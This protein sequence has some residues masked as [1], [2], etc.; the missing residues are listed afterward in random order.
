MLKCL[1]IVF[2]FRFFVNH[3]IFL[4]KIP[5]AERYAFK[6]NFISGPMPF[7]LYIFHGPSATC[8]RK[9]EQTSGEDVPSR[10]LLGSPKTCSTWTLV[11]RTN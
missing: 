7:Y 8:S 5:F 11:G 9:H 2:A 6:L 4:D 10:E 1:L 3:C